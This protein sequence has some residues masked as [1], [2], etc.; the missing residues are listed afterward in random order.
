MTCL[1][2]KPDGIS[3]K[4]RVPLFVYFWPGGGGRGGG[5]RIKGEFGTPTVRKPPSIDTD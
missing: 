1:N 3:I 4:I 2:A 5:V